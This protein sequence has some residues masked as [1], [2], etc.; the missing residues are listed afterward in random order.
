MTP[1]PWRA[2]ADLARRPWAH[3]L[4][5]P[6][7]DRLFEAFSLEEPR[8]GEYLGVREGVYRLADGGYLF[9]RAARASGGPE[10]ITVIPG[11]DAAA[12]VRAIAAALGMPPGR[13]ETLG[14]AGIEAGLVGLEDEDEGFELL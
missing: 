12:L 5:V 4:T 2:W 7:A 9:V 3:A 14:R 11:G 10:A 8:P 6:G 13:I 1:S